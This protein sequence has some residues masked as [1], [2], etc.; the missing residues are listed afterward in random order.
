MRN[1][2]KFVFKQIRTGLRDVK[3]GV[4]ACPDHWHDVIYGMGA[5]S[6]LTAQQMPEENKQNWKNNL[7][8]TY[9]DC[10]K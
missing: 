4:K 5:C 1:L 7:L 2:Q 3:L 9:E 6:D 10:L 8:T